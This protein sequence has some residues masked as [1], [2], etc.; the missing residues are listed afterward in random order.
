MRITA[1]AALNLAFGTK[2]DRPSSTTRTH[3]V[4]FDLSAHAPTSGSKDI[5]QDVDS[6]RLRTTTMMQGPPGSRF[7][8]VEPLQ[9]VDPHRPL[10]NNQHRLKPHQYDFP[11][12]ADAD[13]LRNEIYQ[14]FKYVEAPQS[15]RPPRTASTVS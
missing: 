7:V 13:S 14:L 12:H 11:A 5:K 3:H 4:G 10:L 6:T 8:P 1:S 15:L 9:P 2:A